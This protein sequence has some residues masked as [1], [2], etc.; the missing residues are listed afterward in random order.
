MF[1]L[2]ACNIDWRLTLWWKWSAQEVIENISL[3]HLWQKRWIS[4]KCFTHLLFKT[5]FVLE[6]EFHEIKTFSVYAVA[7]KESLL[8]RWSVIGYCRFRSC[9]AHEWRKAV[10]LCKKLSNSFCPSPSLF[11]SEKFNRSCWI[12]RIF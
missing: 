2:M 4:T 9:R 8:Q 1:S 10:D 5:V 7:N 12:W 6:D 3:Q 11:L